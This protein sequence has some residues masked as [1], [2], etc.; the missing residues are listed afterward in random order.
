MTSPTFSRAALAST[1]ALLL[2]GMALPEAARAQ[3]ER[4]PMTFLDARHMRRAGSQ[5]LSTD[6]RW[7]LYTITTP[8]WQEAESQSDIHL[9][10]VEEGVGSSRQMTY[11]EEKN[12]TS[13]AFSRD[14]R[15][16]LFLSNRDAN[17]NGDRNQLYH[18]RP[19]GGE[20]QRITDESEGVTDF[21]F[22]DDGRWVVYRAGRGSDA[23]LHRLSTEGITEAEAEQ[24]TEQ[25]AGIQSWRWAPDSRRLYFIT[26][27]TLD[28]DANIRRESGFTVDI[29]N[30]ETPLASLWALDLEPKQTTRLTD[31]PTITVANF[32][33]SDDGRWVGF[34]GNSAER[35]ERN[36]T[37][38]RINADLYL[39]EVATGH[40][41]RLTENDEVSEQG[42]S[43]S[44]DGRWIAFVAADDMTRYTMKS[45]RVYIREVTDRGGSF[46]K[47]G[48]SFHDHV[49][50]GFWS[51]DGNTIYFNAGVR[52]TRQLLALDIARD[53]VR[54]VTNLQ[55][56]VRVSRDDDSGVLL[57]NY[58]DPKTPATTFSVASID[59][60]DNR[61][62]WTQLTDVNPQV[63]GFLLGEE[64]EITWRSTDGHE[65]GGVLVKP[66][67]Y[68]EGQRYPLIVAIHGGPASADV[69]GFNGGYGSEVYAGAGYVVLRPNYRGSSNYGEE[70][71]TAIVGDYF[72]QGYEDIMAGVDHL[73]EEGIVDGDRMGA[74]GWSAGGHWSNWILT[75]TDRFK[76]I[77]S[78]A[79]TSNWISMYAQSD[80]QRNR[81]Y[82]LGD[83]LPYLNHDA[84]WEQSPMKYITN[85]KTP[86]MIH[87]VEGD[88]RVPSPQSVE[89]HMGLKKLG[90]DTELFMYPGRSHGIPDPRNRLVK[91]VS[92]MA[93][94]DYYVRG[95]GEKFVWR[96]V[97]KTLEIEEE[98][99]RAVTDGAGGER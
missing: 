31:D 8:D 82:Y 9:V 39:L 95:I 57:I 72:P 73:I 11:T 65:V 45:R 15:F 64:E 6:G 92:E 70:F 25:D 76:A 2:C 80:V 71:R 34:T 59:Q 52:A 68:Q 77:S 91:A 85:A 44:P 67:G 40:I 41:E 47:L 53:E 94:M 23:Q 12:E 30:E 26:P 63:R 55:A 22:S 5:A 99:P 33:I 86:T 88:P 56:S 36:I 10:S 43:F 29:R 84:Y 89:L 96:D 87:V 24:L 17:E 58:A 19:D 7:M 3:D 60:L 1:A 28:A 35:Y 62:A 46:R 49:G 18:M 69:L 14:G 50:L 13:P 74:L 90:V 98:G 75:H 48:G 54:Q 66:V 37:E 38:Q 61:Q 81:Q 42:P 21:A 20:A 4:R 78:G 83:D 97:L 79:G 16:F 27:D 51:E 32:T 93:W